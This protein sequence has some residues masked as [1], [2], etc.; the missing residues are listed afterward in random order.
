MTISAFL[1]ETSYSRLFGTPGL[2]NTFPSLNQPNSLT[3]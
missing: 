2:G 1:I 3:P